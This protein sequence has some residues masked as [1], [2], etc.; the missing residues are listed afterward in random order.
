[1]ATPT[2]KNRY[3]Y[4]FFTYFVKR[5]IGHSFKGNCCFRVALTGG[6]G[7]S[8]LPCVVSLNASCIV[9]DVVLLALLC[10]LNCQY[11]R[12]N[13]LPIEVR[14]RLDPLER[15]CQAGSLTGAVHLS[16]GNAG[17]LR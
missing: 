7:L 12:V 11:K 5:C 9:R 3:F 2:L 14:D 13:Y 6:V 17:V 8:G 10:W 16:K 15:H 4:R 1:M